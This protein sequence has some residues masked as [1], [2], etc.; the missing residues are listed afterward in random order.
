MPVRCET[1]QLGPRVLVRVSGDLSAETAPHVRMALLKSLVEQPDAVVVELTGLS[2]REPAA[3]AVFSAVVRQAAV[4]PG[5]PLLI[6]APDPDQA[7]QLAGGR[8]GRLAVFAS[9]AQALIAKPDNRIP[10]LSEAL[11]PVTGA[12]ARA[13]ALAREACHRWIVPQLTDAAILVT[14]ELVT[15]AMEHAN[16]MIGLRLSMGHRYL[17]IAV[18]DGSTERPR[19]DSGPAGKIATGRGLRLVEELSHR[20][21][22]LLAPDG[23]V[24]WASLAAD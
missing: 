5:T 4:W 11:L 18:R 14:G 10:M 15:N 1:R 7:A 19:L 22:C 24:V 9:A 8:Y 20:W 2:V 16:T 12:A 23:K 3:L 13:R 21:G 17:M 6:A